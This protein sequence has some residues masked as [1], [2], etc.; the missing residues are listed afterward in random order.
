MAKKKSAKC[1]KKCTTS[2][3]K[4][5]TKSKDITNLKKLISE[6]HPEPETFFQKCYNKIVRNSRF[7]YAQDKVTEFYRSGIDRCKKLF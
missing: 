6:A 3:P 4:T 1:K 5:K 2:K 7:I